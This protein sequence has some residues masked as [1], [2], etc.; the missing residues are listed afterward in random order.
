[1]FKDTKASTAP[2]TWNPS[3][4]P[5]LCDDAPQHSLFKALSVLSEIHEVPILV[6]GVSIHFGFPSVFLDSS[7][8]LKIIKIF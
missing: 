2:V 5:V 8:F 3:A 4:F 6:D 7:Q 1:M